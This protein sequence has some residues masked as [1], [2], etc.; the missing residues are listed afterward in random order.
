MLIGEDGPT[1]AVSG[2]GV[3]FATDGRTAPDTI[4]VILEY[5]GKWNATFDATLA[6]GATG[7]GI[8][9]YGTEGRMQIDRKGFT[10]T[11]AEKGAQPTA[12]KATVEQT[13]EHVRNFL[14][15][16][17]TRKEPN[18]DVYIGHRSAQA[19]HLG[20]LA[21]EQKRRIMFNAER[22]EILPL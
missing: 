7:A 5:P 14:D 15:C 2:G 12:V 17:K 10:F 3:Y 16:L 11:P 6:P 19:S 18:G 1:S 4:N 13:E 9:V 21:W 8:E 20:N 22:E